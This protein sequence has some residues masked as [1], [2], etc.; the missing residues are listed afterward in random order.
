MDHLRRSLLNYFSMQP[1]NREAHLRNDEQWIQSALTSPQSFF[2][3]LHKEKIITVEEQPLCLDAEQFNSLNT[4]GLTPLFLGTKYKQ[5]Y[6]A[7]D[8]DDLRH[9]QPVITQPKVVSLR[10]IAD[11]LDMETAS[12]LAYAQ[13]MS[14]WLTGYRFCRRCGNGYI[15]RQG[16]HVLKCSSPSCAHTEFPRINPA[17]IMRVTCG[18]KILLARQPK[19]P[20][21]RYSVL[22]GFV[23][24][25]ETLEH[26]VMRETKEESGI[27][28]DQI[29]YHSSQPWPFPNSLMIGFCVQTR[30]MTLDIEND[31]LESALWLNADELI[32]HMNERTVILSP[33]ISISHRLIEDWFMEQTGRSI[34]E[35]QFIKP[36]H[37]RHEN[38]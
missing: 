1:L 11:D 34:K 37:I 29:Y 31:D 16:G 17:V 6:F 38:E 2:Y 8:F 35:W 14:H 4:V 7:I 13:L 22:A 30:N 32:D 27:D 19:W 23:E 12:V 26:A 15:P 21:N 9:L 33:P 24:T 20:P 10:D 28:V 25:G 36:E 18:D 5:I 3:A